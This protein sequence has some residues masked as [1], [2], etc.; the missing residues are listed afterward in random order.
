MTAGCQDVAAECR[1]TQTLTTV[2]VKNVPRSYNLKDLVIV[3]ENLGFRNSFN[4]VNMH[5]DKSRGKNRGYAFL[6]FHTHTTAAQFL[7]AINGHGWEDKGPESPNKPVEPAWSVWAHVQGLEANVALSKEA[8]TVQ[9]KRKSKTVAQR[10]QQVRR[11]EVCGLRSS[12][13]A[14]E[15]ERRSV[16]SPARLIFL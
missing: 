13:D 2:V 6:N 16:G 5:E 8:S 7:E 12:P 3:I 14:G 9:S 11:R 4:F 1:E 10:K 15:A